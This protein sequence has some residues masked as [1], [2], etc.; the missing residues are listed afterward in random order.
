M[1]YPLCNIKESA[2]IPHKFKPLLLRYTPVFD[3]LPGG[4]VS[5]EEIGYP[6]SASGL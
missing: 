6:L 4:S 1:S 2:L 5:A 3:N